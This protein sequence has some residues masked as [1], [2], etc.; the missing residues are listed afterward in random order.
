VTKAKWD[1]FKMIRKVTLNEMAG[2]SEEDADRIPSGFNNNIRWNLGHIY[3]AAGGLLA[4]F[5]GENTAVPSN[6][7]KLFDR[8]TKPADWQGDVPSL[9]E[10]QKGLEG[11]VEQLEFLFEKRLND[12]LVHPCDFGMVQLTTI[13]ELLD[14]IFFHEGLHAGVIKGLKRTMGL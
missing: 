11:Q 2:M 3:N 5:T 12:A 1:L 6:Y 7:P 10:L 9:S 8:G 14:F 13:G 4:G